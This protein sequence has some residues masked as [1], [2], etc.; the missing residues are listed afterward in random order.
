MH[1]NLPPLLHFLIGE[2]MK[3]RAQD[4]M[5]KSTTLCMLYAICQIDVNLIQVIIWERMWDD[6]ANCHKIH[7]AWQK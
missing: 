6:H 5:V 3:Y 4:A 7:S 1:K 2:G